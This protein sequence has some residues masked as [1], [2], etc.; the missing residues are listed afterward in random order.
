[1]AVVAAA[2]VAQGVEFGELAA[3]A[4]PRSVGFA[5]TLADGSGDR[6]RSAG[7][8]IYA[9]GVGGVVAVHNGSGLQLQTGSR[10]LWYE[11]TDCLWTTEPCTPL[12]TAGNEVSLVQVYPLTPDAST[13]GQGGLLGLAVGETR[14]AFVKFYFSNNTTTGF[15]TLCMDPRDGGNGICAISAESTAPLVARTSATS[16][17]VT[18]G[19]GTV[20]GRSD[21]AELIR[22]TGS[23]KRSVITVD[24]AFS[25]PFTMT[26]QC[27]VAS[28]CPI[29]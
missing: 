2:V 26:I 12:F 5:V 17:T 21:V 13:L 9:N 23:G 28:D 19:P 22:E 20:G 25:L 27:L 11:L 8:Q 15:W 29:P 24:G 10:G 18:A 7:G 16:W 1:M 4:K 14:P 3:R 6:V